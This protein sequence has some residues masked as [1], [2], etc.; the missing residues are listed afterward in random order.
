MSELKVIGFT[1]PKRSGKDTAADAL[2]REL[3]W[4]KINPGD[5]I[6]AMTK[7]LLRHH[8]GP[9]SE[10]MIDAHVDGDLRE[11]AVLMINR[12]K[13]SARH[14]M[15]TLGDDW[16]RDM[17]H[18]DLFACMMHTAAVKA[19]RRGAPGVVITGIR[20]PNEARMVRMLDGE[21]WRIK[22]PG[23]EAT[24][25]HTSE[26]GLDDLPVTATFVNDGSPE[27]LQRQVLQLAPRQGRP[28]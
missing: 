9:G 18:P 17:I 15:Q 26:Q 24:G 23:Y 13:I 2:V 8:F 22:R 14:M 11:E 4:V 5:P 16:G 3:G 21:L 27:D 25:E 12:E 20:K 10:I 6:R 7:A 19:L 28:S 1:G